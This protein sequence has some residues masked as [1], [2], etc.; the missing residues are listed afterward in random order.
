MPTIFGAR[1]VPADCGIGR[2][3]AAGATCTLSL[4]FGPRDIG[5]RQATLVVDAPQLAALAFLTLTGQ[6]APSAAVPDTIDVI[7]FHNSRDGQYSSQPIRVKSACSTVARSVR[8]GR[9]PARRFALGRPTMRR[10]ARLP[11]CRF[12]GT[13]GVGP[14]SHF[15]TAYEYECAIVRTTPKWIEEGVTFR[16]R[17]P[18]QGACDSGDTTVLRLWKANEAIVA[19]RRRYV[20]DRALAD[21][22]QRDGWGS[23]ARCSARLDLNHRSSCM[24]FRRAHS[25]ERRSSCITFR[26]ARILDRR[27]SCIAFLRA[28]I[29]ASPHRAAGVPSLD[30]RETR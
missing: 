27:T 20:V 26:R 23:K 6:G 21:A 9:A 28:S 4:F 17:P 3:I 19:S 1:R 7:E 13:P 5:Q 11:V 22:M 18:I 12:F 2:A 25:L 15:Y 24:A 29:D 10:T 14:N 16:A 30:H 8:T